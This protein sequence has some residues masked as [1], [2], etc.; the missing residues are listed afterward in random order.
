MNTKVELN[1]NDHLVISLA[2]KIL[3][4]DLNEIIGSGLCGKV[5]NEQIR[6]AIETRYK[7]NEVIDK[8][9]LRE[10]IEE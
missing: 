7:L 2:L 8:L 9:G 1:Q 10:F 5:S 4:D 6:E 3:H